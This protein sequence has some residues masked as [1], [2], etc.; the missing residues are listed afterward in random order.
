MISRYNVMKSSIVLDS[1]GDNQ[2]YPDTL[3]VDFSSIKFT[4]PPFTYD[5]TEQF[6]YKP[7]SVT[8][9]FYGATANDGLAGYDDLVLNMN[10]IAHISLVNPINN[11]IILNIPAST[12][13]NAF[14]QNNSNG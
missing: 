12:D 10:N 11:P 8:V 3:S 7:W 4:E 1:Q 14:V 13:M 2:P 9:R 6:L 5:P